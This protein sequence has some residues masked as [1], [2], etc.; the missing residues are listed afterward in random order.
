MRDK[1][2]MRNVEWR[3]GHEHV[4][5]DQLD[6]YLEHMLSERANVDTRQKI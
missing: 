6:T 4:P 5:H 3:R 2:R 1:S